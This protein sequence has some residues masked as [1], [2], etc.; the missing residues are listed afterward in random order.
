M[1]SKIPISPVFN[2]RNKANIQPKRYAV[3]SKA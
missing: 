1:N 2:K 3:P